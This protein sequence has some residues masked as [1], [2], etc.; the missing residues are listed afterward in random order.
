MREAKLNMN[1]LIG[2]SSR[3]ARYRELKPFVR[4]RRDSEISPSKFCFAFQMLYAQAR[5]AINN[6]QKKKNLDQSGHFFDKICFFVPWPA[7]HGSHLTNIDDVILVS[8]RVHIEAAL[9]SF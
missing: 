7:L 1:I 6:L 4:L 3:D 8:P 5:L 2:S 9:M